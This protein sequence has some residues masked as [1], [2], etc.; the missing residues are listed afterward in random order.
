MEC[1]CVELGSGGAGSIEEKSLRQIRKG[2]SV[3]F[4]GEEIT[5]ASTSQPSFDLILPTL[6]DQQQYRK[7]LGPQ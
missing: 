5:F 2:S 1:F 3:S 6:S 7:S 4:L